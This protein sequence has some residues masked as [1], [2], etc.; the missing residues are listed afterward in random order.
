MSPDRRHLHN[1]NERVVLDNRSSESIS[2]IL[3]AGCSAESGDSSTRRLGGIPGEFRSTQQA[4]FDRSGH[5]T[6]CI[7]VGSG[8]PSR[9]R[10]LEC[11]V[12]S[13]APSCS[14]HCNCSSLGRILTR[15]CRGKVR[16]VSSI[17]MVCSQ[18]PVLSRLRKITLDSYGRIRPDYHGYRRY[19]D[20]HVGSDD[21][22]PTM[23]FDRVAL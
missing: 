17:Q 23:K 21:L 12:A 20:L 9:F 15:L 13:D 4:V 22:H 18:Y 6:V 11:A 2:H 16:R 5:R 1:A 19:I 3:A 10:H 7:S 8:R 14:R